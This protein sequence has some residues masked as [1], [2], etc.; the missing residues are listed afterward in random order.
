M[1]CGSEHNWLNNDIFFYRFNVLTIKTISVA[2]SVFLFVLQTSKFAGEMNFK[3]VA[4]TIFVFKF[5]KAVATQIIVG[6]NLFY[7]P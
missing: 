4:L 7:F 2:F 6:E 5:Y 3:F 1:G